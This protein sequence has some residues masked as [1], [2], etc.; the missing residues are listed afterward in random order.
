MYLFYFKVEYIWVY[1]GI[2]SRQL[3]G[4]VLVYSGT[5]CTNGQ[6]LFTL[7]RKRLSYVR[8]IGNWFQLWYD[9]HGLLKR[10]YLSKNAGMYGQNFIVVTVTNTLTELSVTWWWIMGLCSEICRCSLKD[11]ERGIC[12]NRLNY[13]VCTAD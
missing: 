7:L 2:L 12:R 11:V 8:K 13:V 5:W 3:Q 4:P 1:S 9:F 10:K 6:N